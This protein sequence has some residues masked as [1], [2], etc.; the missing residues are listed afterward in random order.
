MTKDKIIVIGGGASG[1]FS[2]INSVLNNPNLNVVILEKSTKLLSK[3]K[4][5]GGGRCNVTHN[6]TINS[7]L[8]NNYPRGNK[9]LLQLFN[10]FN[11]NDTIKWFNNN[12][13]NLNIEEDGRMFPESNSSQSIIDCFI[14]LT[15]K[16]KIKICVN[17]EV[18]SITQ[19]NNLF[20]VKTNTGILQA[21]KIVCCIGGH[22]KTGHYQFLKNLGHTIIEPI[23]SLF[24]FNLTNN[25]INKALQ[26]VSVKNVE[27][28]LNG[29]KTK[30]YGALLITHWGFSGPAV[31]KLSAF[32]AIELA[33]L[34]YKCNFSINWMGGLK[35]NE[36]EEIL[37]QLKFEKR[38]ALPYSFAPNGIPKRMWE[39]FLK[40]LNFSTIK[41]WAEITKKQ[42]VKLAELLYNNYFELNGKTTFKEEFVTCGG[43]DLKEIDFKTMESKIKPGLYFCGEVINVDGIT[44]GF[45]FQNAWSTAWVAAKNCSND[46]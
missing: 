38:N 43:V 20:E 14:N 28:K 6:C 3:V 13:I 4:I 32:A 11:V 41:P 22:N 1:F 17:T 45:N 8:V 36:I 34:N 46:I 24:T 40:E 39:Y 31:I 19:N 18:F 16:L 25:A 10:K 12:G 35:L 44:G 9:A 42:I 21:N 7:L 30:S 23:P 5:S 15:H 33:K 27:I 2:A 37:N 26:G 29:I